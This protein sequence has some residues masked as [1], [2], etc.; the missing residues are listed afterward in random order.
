ML[1]N[2]SSDPIYQNVEFTVVS[3]LAN[4]PLI[5]GYANKE[6]KQDTPMRYDYNGSVPG[7]YDTTFS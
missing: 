7:L 6:I 3:G 1:L 4:K 5:I 2:H